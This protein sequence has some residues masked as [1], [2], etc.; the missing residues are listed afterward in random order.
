MNSFVRNFIRRFRGRESFQ[1]LVE[2]LNRQE[3]KKDLE[4]SVEKLVRFGK[5]RAL[6]VFIE[7]LNHESM[8][9]RG[10]A[11]YGISLIPDMSAVL[12]LL[13]AANINVRGDGNMIHLYYYFPLSKAFAA[14]AD[15]QPEAS[16]PVLLDLIAG[17]STTGTR[18]RAGTSRAVIHEGLD[19]T[20]NP[21][22][23]KILIEALQSES[24]GR[25]S[26]AL[27]ALETR[28]YDEDV[29]HALEKMRIV[30][31]D[32][33]L[34]SVLRDLLSPNMVYRKMLGGY[35][36]KTIPELMKVARDSDNWLANLAAALLLK[37][38]GLPGMSAPF[39]ERNIEADIPRLA[40]MLEPYEFPLSGWA[41]FLLK[42]IGTP[43]AVAIA[44]R[45]DKR[46]R[47]GRLKRKDNGRNQ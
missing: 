32:G 22:V 10:A 39:Y 16:V 35:M 8:L 42:Q 5:A 45:W 34:R 43:E 21:L 41:Y 26:C 12:A 23:T 4:E 15:A 24:Y 25:R 14:I 36:T 47:Q 20:L 33:Q 38:I 40:E 3:Y 9:K 18:R 29:I 28:T 37:D 6:P 17:S 7:L 44:N 2:K 27:D 13:K 46:R 1:K 11:A 30:E 31:K 19:W